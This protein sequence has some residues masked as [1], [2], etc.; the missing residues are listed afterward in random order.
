MKRVEEKRRAMRRKLLAAG[1]RDVAE[2]GLRGFTMTEAAK[3]AGCSIGAV[4]TH[5]AT[6]QVF[7]DALVDVAYAPLSDAIDRRMETDETADL[8]LAATLRFILNHSRK[9]RLWA[10]FR[11]ETLSTSRAYQRGEGARI[12]KL[13]RRGRRERVFDL[14]NAIGGLVFASS[15]LFLQ[16]AEL[17][18]AF[19]DQAHVDRAVEKLLIGLGV[20]PTQ[21]QTALLAPGLVVD[22]LE[23]G[24][25][26]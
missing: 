8:I 7:I 4:Y 22:S 14:E 17:E 24:V 9:D 10:S 6:P 20:D 3:Q 23:I 1:Y 11:C 15:L 16:Q 12:E 21:T 26:E 2:N 19:P 25:N 18:K 5:F 13:V